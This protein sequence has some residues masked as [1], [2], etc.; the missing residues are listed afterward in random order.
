MYIVVRS[1]LNECG[2][3][4]RGMFVCYMDHVLNV[5][6]LFSITDLDAHVPEGRS[7]HVEDRG[8]RKGEG[9]SIGWGFVHRLERH[10][11]ETQT[12]RT[13]SLRSFGRLVLSCIKAVCCKSI[14][15]LQ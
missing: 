8:R 10:L 5:L 6:Y 7:K 12:G 13:L 15:I 14:L 11:D 4:E 3:Y 2:N 1:N 9:V